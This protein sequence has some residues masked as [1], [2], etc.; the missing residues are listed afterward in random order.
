[1]HDQIDGREYKLLLE[2]A[3]FGHAPSLDTA[4]G[5]WNER[6]KPI[7]EARL[8]RPRRGTRC[9]RQFDKAAERTI[10]FFDTADHVLAGADYALRLRMPARSKDKPEL[11][12][13]L[14]MPDLFIV[15]STELTARSDETDPCLEEDIA[16]LEV[17][18]PRK[19]GSV[20][21]ASP[22]S[23]RSRF[24]LS[25]SQRLRPSMRLRT[26]GDVFRLYPTLKANLQA[27]GAQVAPRLVLRSGPLIRETVFRGARVRFGDGVAGKLVLTHWH[28]DDPAAEVTRI[29]ELSY[30]C[31][32]SKRPMSADAARR[33]FNLFCGLQEGL[34]DMVNLRHASKTALA[35]P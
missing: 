15:A 17:A 34:R 27:S 25:S 18:D 22:T 33:A 3:R 32:L 21:I 12:L 13:K 4:N 35:L 28:F 31:D 16:P 11:T 5:F 29:A 24:A 9:E 20:T 2:S 26:L 7:I 6:L 10:R 1:M 23:I 19:P 8:D 14:R 30:C